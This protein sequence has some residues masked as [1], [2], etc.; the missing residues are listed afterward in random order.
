MR[1]IDR[2]ERFSF[3]RDV[4]TLIKDVHNVKFRPACST[5]VDINRKKSDILFVRI[6]AGMPSLNLLP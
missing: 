2:T 6:I 3:Y 4:R 1:K 5:V